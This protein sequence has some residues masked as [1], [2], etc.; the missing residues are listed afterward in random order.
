MSQKVAFLFATPDG[1]THPGRWERFFVDA[2]VDRC[3]LYLL[4]SWKE[5]SVPASM[6][7]A[8]VE[9]EPSVEARVALLSAALMDPLNAA[10]VV[11]EASCIPVKPC[12]EVCASIL[13]GNASDSHVA[14]REEA[15]SLLTSL[16][17]DE[18]KSESIVVTSLSEDRL[19][20]LEAAPAQFACR[21]ARRCQLLLADGRTGRL[22]D[23]P[24][25]SA[26]FTATL[27][28]AM[29]ADPTQVVMP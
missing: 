24:I 20:E 7:G 29:A 18:L 11:L 17:P 5:A 19:A 22:D 16:K 8:R 25:C 9:L 21:F 14:T 3:S 10:F 13:A 28:A 23:H 27:A 2:P 4:S 26:A 12:S 1:V 6:L 15:L